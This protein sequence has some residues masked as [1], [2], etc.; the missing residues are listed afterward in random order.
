M[1]LQYLYSVIMPCY[2]QAQRL[3]E[4]GEELSSVKIQNPKKLIEG[5]IIEKRYEIDEESRIHIE[6]VVHC[7]DCLAGRKLI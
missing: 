4:E 3:L 7:P 6:C 2:C 1:N 5:Y